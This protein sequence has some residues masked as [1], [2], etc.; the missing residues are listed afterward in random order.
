MR[1]TPN[2]AAASFGQFFWGLQKMLDSEKMPETGRVY[3]TVSI[4]VKQTVTWLKSEEGKEYMK[5]KQ[6]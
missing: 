1:G 4:D 6:P 2:V 3:Y 5:N